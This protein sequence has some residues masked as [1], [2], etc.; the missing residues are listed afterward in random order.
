[1]LMCMG[2]F[3]SPAPTLP[4]AGHPSLKLPAGASSS[5]KAASPPFLLH[6]IVFRPATDEHV[7][8]SP[9]QDVCLSSMSQSEVS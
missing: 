4:S 3:R 2:S 7:F 9:E 8:E 6:S 1:M 5:D